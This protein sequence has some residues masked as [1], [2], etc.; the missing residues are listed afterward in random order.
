MI[1]KGISTNWRIPLPFFSTISHWNRLLHQVVHLKRRQRNGAKTVSVES[2]WGLHYLFEVSQFLAISKCSQVFRK[3][4]WFTIY[5]ICMNEE[6]KRDYPK[7]I[8]TVNSQTFFPPRVKN[9]GKARELR[10]SDPLPSPTSTPHPL[11]QVEPVAGLKIRR[12]FAWK[13]REG[14]KCENILLTALQAKL[15]WP[16]M[17]TKNFVNYD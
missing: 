7:C 11:H 10:S 2:H 13:W 6:K 8:W 15:S 17:F 1:W 4:P 5:N 14:S 16:M 9:N 12:T 3:V